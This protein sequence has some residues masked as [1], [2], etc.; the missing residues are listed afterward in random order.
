MYH[1]CTPSARRNRTTI[2]IRTSRVFAQVGAPVASCT[3]CTCGYM[4]VVFMYGDGGMLLH[5]VVVVFQCHSWKT[6]P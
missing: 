4:I 6:H 5:V 1:T 3:R 2:C